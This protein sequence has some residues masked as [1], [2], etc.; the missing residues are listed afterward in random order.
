[1]TRSFKSFPGFTVR[2]GMKR[3]DIR[4]R[5]KEEDH[6]SKGRATRQ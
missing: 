4:E 2:E 3:E 6:D 1:M 5:E